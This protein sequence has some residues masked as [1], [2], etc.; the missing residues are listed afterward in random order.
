MANSPKLKAVIF[1]LDGLMFNTEELYQYVGGR[2]LK[3]RGKEF[4]DELLD[5]MMGT[6]Q[7]VALQLM[8]DY[9][10]LDATVADLSRETEEVFR[11]DPRR[12]TRLYARTVGTS[13]RA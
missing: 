2:L 10:G 13:R 6:P 9:H 8:I 11:G 1:D 3:R 4:D 5:K 12:T 7:R